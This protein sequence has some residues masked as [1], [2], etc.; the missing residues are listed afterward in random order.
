MAAGVD[1]TACRQA[2]GHACLRPTVY[3]TLSVVCFNAMEGRKAAEYSFLV[4]RVLPVFSAFRQS[5]SSGSWKRASI[6]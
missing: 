3:G 5:L 2:Q 6:P 4:F 1:C